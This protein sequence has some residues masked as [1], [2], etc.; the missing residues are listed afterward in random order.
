MLV[1]H[2]YTSI[3]LFYVLRIWNFQSFFRWWFLLYLNSQRMILYWSVVR[4]FELSSDFCDMLAIASHNQVACDCNVMYNVSK[5]HVH[6]DWYE[7]YKF[8]MYF[9]VGVHQ[10]TLSGFYEFGTLYLTHKFNISL[11]SIHPAQSS[12]FDVCDCT[13]TGQHTHH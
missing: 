5:V 12:L 10:W 3:L 4:K 6:Q 8:L 11:L 2:F 13:C 7:I 9:L 1:S